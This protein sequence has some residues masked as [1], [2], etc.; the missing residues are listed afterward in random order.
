MTLDKQLLAPHRPQ[1]TMPDNVTEFRAGDTLSFGVTAPDQ[2]AFIYANY[3][4]AYGSVLTLSQPKLLPPTPL[5]PN[6]QQT[7]GDGKDHR[8]KFTVSPPLGK[9]MI[10]VL[11]SRSPLF[12]DPLPDTMTEREY[13]TKVR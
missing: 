2:P 5:L 4:A 9:E 3:V 1:I 6:T 8:D 10:V 7:F 12:A 13:L 11:A